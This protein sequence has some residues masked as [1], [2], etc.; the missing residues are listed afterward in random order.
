MSWEFRVPKAG[1]YRVEILQGCGPGSGGSEVEFSVGDETL[2]VKV[3]ETKGFQDFLK[4]DIGEFHFAQAGR[5]T[6][7]VKPK[8]KPGQAVMD[9]R[10]VTLR[11][12]E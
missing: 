5:F 1:N 8:N 2:L 7:T 11:P 10:S 4:R 6:L 9:L 12:A 3:V